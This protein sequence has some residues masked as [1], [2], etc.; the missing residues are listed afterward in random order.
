MEQLCVVPRVSYLSGLK[1]IK[2][3]QVN[4]I[5]NAKQTSECRFTDKPLEWLKGNSELE[6][7]EETME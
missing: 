4:Q 6:K 3:S 1:P 7:A 2:Q 5:G